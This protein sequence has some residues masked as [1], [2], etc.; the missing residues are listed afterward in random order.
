MVFFIH[1]YVYL[2][3]AVKSYASLFNDNETGAMTRLEIQ[4][5]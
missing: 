5:N 2:R 4:F 3:T 1:N